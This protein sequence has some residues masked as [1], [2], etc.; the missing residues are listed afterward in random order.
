MGGAVI[1]LSQ[2]ENASDCFLDQSGPQTTSAYPDALVTASDHGTNRL[3]VRIEH[4]PGLIIGMADV[5]AGDRLLLTNLTHECH[6]RTP[7]PW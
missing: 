4:T 3:N 5:V 6:D 1:L 2:R 7:C